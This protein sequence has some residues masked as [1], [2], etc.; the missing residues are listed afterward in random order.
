MN[1]A[2]VTSAAKWK[3]TFVHGNGLSSFQLVASLNYPAGE[4]TGGHGQ[5][6]THAARGSK[7]VRGASHDGP[8]Q[9]G[10]QLSTTEPGHTKGGR[11][12]V[13]PALRKAYPTK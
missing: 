8:D 5:G 7:H 11:S 1:S 3:C 6:P 2:V 9:I 13:S 4:A 10:P 12:I